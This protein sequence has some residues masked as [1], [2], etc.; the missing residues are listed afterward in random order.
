M[1]GLIC[2]VNRIIGLSLDGR[3]LT[4]SQIDPPQKWNPLAYWNE[5]WN[6]SELGSTISPPTILLSFSMGWVALKCEQT[7]IVILLGQSCYYQEWDNN[8]Q[9]FDEFSSPCAIM[10]CL[11]TNVMGYKFTISPS[12]FVFRILYLL[13]VCGQVIDPLFGLDSHSYKTKGSK[14]ETEHC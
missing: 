5:I 10:T 3:E 14:R 11:N 8:L 7:E 12:D 4:S 2:F 6:G 9:V 13:E 1:L